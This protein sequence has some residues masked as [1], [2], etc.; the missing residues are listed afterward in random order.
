MVWAE[1]E[2]VAA[3]A[4]AGATDPSVPTAQRSRHALALIEAVDPLATA[5]VE[6]ALPSDPDG[7]EQLGLV[8]L[9]ALAE[10]VHQLPL[11]EASDNA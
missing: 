4:L 7:V 10:Q 11:I 8:E 2:R 3:A 5:S 6:L 1:R 9:K